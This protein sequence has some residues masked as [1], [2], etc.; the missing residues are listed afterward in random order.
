MISTESFRL[1]GTGLSRHEAHGLWPA[2]LPPAL[3][4]SPG[5]KLQVFL[6]QRP[7][8]FELLF[9]HFLLGNVGDQA[10]HGL[11][12]FTG[13]FF[14]LVFEQLVVSEYEILI[15]FDLQEVPDPDGKFG[16]VNRLCKKIVCADLQTLKLRAPV[17]KRGDDNNR[18]VRGLGSDFR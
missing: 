15:F 6:L 4:Q 17:R 16:L 9:K 12:Q 5:K 14:D 18:Y 11:L 13:S 2:V 10:E 7:G 1:S 3:D 8:F